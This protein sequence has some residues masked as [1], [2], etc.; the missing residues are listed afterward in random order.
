MHRDVPGRS[1][2]LG[3]V[4]RQIRTQ[5]GLRQQHHGGRTALSPHQQIALE[6]ADA[7]VVVERHHGEDHVN[8]GG[9]DL[10][11]GDVAGHPP[12][13][14]APS[15]EHGDDG[16][17]VFVRLFAEDDPI[18]NDRQLT[19]AF[20]AV[21]EASGE[22]GLD[23][24]ILDADT[25]QVVEPDDDAPRLEACLPGPRVEVSCSALVPAQVIKRHRSARRNAQGAT[26]KAHR[27]R[28]ALS[29]VH[30]ALCI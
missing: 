8:V 11:I 19:T 25:I 24:A 4:C 14:A 10:L 7:E 18:A 21:L 26:P 13:K 3:D 6:P 5:V 27:E 16:A 20:R 28:G 12:R 29:L 17:A 22:H 15:R 2:H 1:H 23:L 30:C 9:D